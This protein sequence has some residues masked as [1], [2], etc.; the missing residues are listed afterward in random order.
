MYT[1]KYKGPL[2]TPDT[3]TS[4]FNFLIIQKQEKGIFEYFLSK[5]G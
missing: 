3:M 5:K 2:G 1:R 4:L